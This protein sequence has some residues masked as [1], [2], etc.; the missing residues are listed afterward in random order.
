MR[1][2]RK[3]EECVTRMI[4]NKR[5]QH[6]FFSTFSPLKIIKIDNSMALFFLLLLPTIIPTA[7]DEDQSITA[8]YW[9]KSLHR[10]ACDCM[11]L[12]QYRSAPSQQISLE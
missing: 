2:R 7:N 6:Q 9:R 10:R 3:I 11:V 8:T 12:L 5:T 1:R 4:I